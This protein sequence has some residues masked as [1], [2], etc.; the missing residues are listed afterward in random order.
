[1][2]GTFLSNF[3]VTFPQSWDFLHRGLKLLLTKDFGQNLDSRDKVIVGDLG[4]GLSQVLIVTRSLGSVNGVVSA[5]APG[6]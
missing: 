5:H 4:L 2:P 6:A 3:G 1:M